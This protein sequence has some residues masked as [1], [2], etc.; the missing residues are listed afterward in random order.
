MASPNLHFVLFPLLTPGHMVPMIDMARI[1]AQHGSNVT[2]ITT[3]LNANR[4][5][6][7]IAR[8][9]KANLKIQ[10]IEVKLKL[11][12]VGLPEGCESFDTLPSAELAYKLF[13]AITMLKE[14]SVLV[15]RELSPVPSCIISDSYIP[16]TSDVAQTLSIPRLVFHGPGCFWMMC[17]HVVFT[18]NVLAGIESD[19][20]PFVLPELP[21]RIEVTKL[22]VMGSSRIDLTDLSGFRSRVQ[23]AEKS[24]YGFVVNSFDE[25]E[26]EYVKGGNKAAVNEHDC[27]EWLDGKDP[28]SVM[29]ICL[30]TLTRVPTEQVIEL[31]LGLESTNIPFIWC[32]RNETEELQRWFSESGFEERVGD[33]GLLIHG[34]APQVMILSHRALGG[35]ITHCGWNSTLEAVCAG[36]PMVTW[37]HLFDQFLNERFITEVLKIGV[38]IEIEIPADVA[39]QDK[40]LVK[41]EEVKAAIECLMDE[42][43]EG[44]QRRKRAQE[45]AEMAKKAMEEGGSSHLNVTS[46]IQDVTEQLAKNMKPSHLV[47]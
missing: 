41:K 27:L 28:G 31:G 29:Y 1:L 40:A 13:T 12:E 35:F 22:Q 17:M 34:W 39:E 30:G 19:S 47:V 5:K 20:Q 15:L 25:L 11:A 10:I 4:Y 7:I 18:T 43:E 42:G 3:P 46:M 16:W 26:P 6:P 36:L 2:I 21:G 8:A 14:P 33:R 32:I 24:S 37:P 45:L 44:E 9:V 23:E 38:R